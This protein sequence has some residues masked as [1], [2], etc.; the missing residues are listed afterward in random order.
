MNDGDARRWRRAAELFDA[1]LELDEQERSRRLDT[2]C[3]D[4]PLLRLRVER[5]LRADASAGHLDQGIEDIARTAL[6]AGDADLRVGECF[7]PY[8]I[9]RVIGRGGMG[10][11]Y[12]ARRQEADFERVVALKLTRVGLGGADVR[13][14]FLAERRLLAQ[15]EHP[16]IARLYD[17]GLGPEGQPWYAMEYVDGLP[18]TPWCDQQR[19]PLVKRL[20]L[21]AKVCDAVDHAHRHLIVHRDIKPANILVDTRGEPRLL[22]FGI[23]RL[24]VSDEPGDR[25]DTALMTPDY[26][27]PEQLRGEAISTATDVYALGAVLFELLTGRRPF[28]DALG[29]REPPSASRACAPGTPDLAAREAARG[30]GSA[31]SLRKALRGDLDRVLLAA[32]DIDPAR[33]YRSAAALADDLRAV[34]RNEPISLRGDRGYRMAKFVGRHRWA[35]AA[36]LAAVVALVGASGAALWQARVAEERAR[37]ATAVKDLVAGL[38]ST[39]S[40]EASPGRELGVRE[41]LDRGRERLAPELAQQPVVAAELL[42]VM[43]RSYASLGDVRMAWQLLDRAKSLSPELDAS[44]KADIYSARLELASRR[45][46]IDQMRAEGAALQLLLPGITQPADRITALLALSFY[47]QAESRDTAE[48]YAVEALRLAASLPAHDVRRIR[49]MRLLADAKDMAGKK[50]EA[51]RLHEQALQ[52]A[53]RNLPRRHPEIATLRMQ[54][55]T[56]YVE[57]RRYALAAALTRQSLDDTVAVYGENSAEAMNALIWTARILMVGGNYRQARPHMERA[58]SI[59]RQRPE[60]SLL[61]RSAAELNLARI[62]EATGELEAAQRLYQSALDGLVESGRESHSLPYLR[63][64]VARLLLRRGQHAPAKALYQ[65]VLNEAAPESAA[66]GLALSGLGTLAR[67]DGDAA[68]ALSMHQ[69]AVEKLKP[70]R[71][72]RYRT[73]QFYALGAQLEVSRD[74]RRLGMQE[75]SRATLADV[76]EGLETGF[77]Y[78]SP[79]LAD[80]YFELAALTGSTAERRRLLERGLGLRKQISGRRQPPAAD[81][82]PALASRG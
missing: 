34:A 69:Q 51:Q 37:T 41:A 26:A 76:V 32:L 78:E 19:L 67:M 22:D 6:E 8:R 66:Y 31:G 13:R 1:L 42:T 16:H 61:D 74:Q 68:R 12:L 53:Q 52:E 7:G 36:S 28:A 29:S 25:G 77:P 62:E 27:A 79:D 57:Q 10:D 64:N 54:L 35:V 20:P 5:L 73:T 15:L 40:V 9:E 38:L 80:A 71:K 43:A 24:M 48:A 70:H 59:I 23:A 30:L 18:V 47:W 3:G 2:E 49:A 60:E 55:A 11:I 46:S 63:L 33:R 72:G 75:A 45:G 39:A 58:M 14:R 21:F 50:E 81:T 56:D 4:D 44:R 17:G 65:R 82:P